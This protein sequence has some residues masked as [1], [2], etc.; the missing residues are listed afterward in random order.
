[1]AKI[2]IGGIIG[3]LILLM[4]LGTLLGDNVT[5]TGSAVKNAGESYATDKVID[6]SGQVIEQLS[7]QSIDNACKD[8]SSTSCTNTKNSVSMIT[9]AW[10]IFIVAIIID[11]LIGFSKWIIRTVEFVSDLF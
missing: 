9:L 8:P 7:E 10:T 1:M 5:D 11:G 6:S 2:T 3:G 4:I